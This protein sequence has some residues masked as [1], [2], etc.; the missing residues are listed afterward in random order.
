VQRG[1]RWEER[2]GAYDSGKSRCGAVVSPGEAIL[3]H[4]GEA[5]TSHAAFVGPPPQEHVAIV[6][7]LKTLQALPPG[8]LLVVIR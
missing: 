6:L 3:V 5:R 2:A 1:K 8:S 4:G 7:F